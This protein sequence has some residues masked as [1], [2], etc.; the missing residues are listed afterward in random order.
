MPTKQFREVVIGGRIKHSDN[1]IMQAAAKYAV[2]MSVNNGV[3]INKNKYANKIDKLYA[4]LYAY[5]IAFKED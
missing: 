4:T 3:R 5:A 1:R 2:L